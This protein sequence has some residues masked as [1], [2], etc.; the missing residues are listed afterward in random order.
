MHLTC[1]PPHRPRGPQ[2]HQQRRERELRCRHWNLGVTRQAGAH[3]PT[4]PAACPQPCLR[5]NPGSRLGV[6]G[7]RSTHPTTSQA[8]G[9]AERTHHL[10]RHIPTQTWTGRE[11]SPTPVVP[12]G[13]WAL[14]LER[15]AWARKGSL[16]MGCS[17]PPDPAHPARC[18]LLSSPPRALSPRPSWWNSQNTNSFTI[19]QN[20]RQLGRQ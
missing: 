14:H 11:G 6:V 2:K 17:L 16:L 1:H 5:T 7:K 19:S 3:L 12:G 13:P 18:Q 20:R 4:V 10:P 15:R 8:Q 9:S